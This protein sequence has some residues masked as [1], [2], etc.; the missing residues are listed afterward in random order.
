MD[1]QRWIDGL[2]LTHSPPGS[3]G[4]IIHSMKRQRQS[5]DTPREATKGDGGHDD[6]SRDIDDAAL[7]SRLTLR[8]VSRGSSP[9]GTNMADLSYAKPPILYHAIHQDNKDLPDTVQL[10]RQGVLR[11]MKSRRVIP[12]GLRSK[13]EEICKERQPLESAYD[14]STDSDK[15]QQETEKLLLEGVLKISKSAMECVRDGKPEP[16]C[17]E[18]VVRPLLELASDYWRKGR[19]ADGPDICIENTTTASTIPRLLPRDSKGN[20]YASKKT[21]Y[22]MYVKYGDRVRKRL[23]LLEQ[24]ERTINQTLA[25]YLHNK[26]QIAVME[27]K[28]AIPNK[29]PLIQL[30]VWSFALLNR[31]RLLLPSSTMKTIPPVAAL[32]VIGHQWSIYYVHC[33]ETGT[34]K[35]YG[36]E[37]IGSTIEVEDIFQIIRVIGTIADYAVD[38]YWPWLDENILSSGC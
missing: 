3:V 8:P 22:G 9:S 19:R 11:Y 18:E 37:N 38:K 32:Q 1:V 35:L 36:P 34:T 33:D 7:G 2:P 21:D 13:I 15:G 14:S 12:A 16:S 20:R 23:E 25:S 31:L 24:G 30:A 10:L 27:L 17:G 29:D 6:S 28:K 5:M 26:P 4:D